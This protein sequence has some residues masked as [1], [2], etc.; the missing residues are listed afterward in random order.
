MYF[1][2]RREIRTEGRISLQFGIADGTKDYIFFTECK[3]A[4]ETLAD[5]LNRNNVAPEHIAD[6]VEDLF[7]T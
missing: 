4:A 7:Y 5:L 2:K 6:I 1:V 3:G